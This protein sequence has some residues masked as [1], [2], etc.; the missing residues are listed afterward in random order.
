MPPITLTNHSYH[1]QQRTHCVHTS[2]EKCTSGCG[3]SFG[4]DFQKGLE[5]QVASC[6]QSYLRGKNSILGF[7]MNQ[8]F[9]P[10]QAGFRRMHKFCFFLHVNKLYTLA[11]TCRG[12]LQKWVKHLAELAHPVG[13]IRPSR[14]PAELSALGS[15]RPWSPPPSCS[16]SSRCYNKH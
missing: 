14:S 1:R 15:G 8:M 12:M 10:C 9:V 4:G 6:K 13:G 16:W 3:V 2:L 7:G 11:S 5:L